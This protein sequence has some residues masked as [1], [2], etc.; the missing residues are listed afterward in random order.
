MEEAVGETGIADLT[1]ILMRTTEEDGTG[2]VESWIMMTMAGEGDPTQTRGAGATT[3][4]TTM[5]T[6]A[7]AGA[8]AGET[9]D[10][11]EEAKGDQTLTQEVTMEEI[12]VEVI[13]AEVTTVEEIMAEVRTV[14]VTGQEAG[15]ESLLRPLRTRA[16]MSVSSWVSPSGSLWPSSPSSEEL[17]STNTDTEPCPLMSEEKNDLD[18]KYF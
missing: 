12:M 6:G 15:L 17:S 8:A 1:Q 9:M 10:R 5:A 16:L 14:E 13:M 11:V 4:T 18:S 7:M 3:T 2:A